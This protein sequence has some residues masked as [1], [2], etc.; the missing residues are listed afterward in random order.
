MFDAVRNN[1]K[2]VN[3]FLMLIILPFAFWGVES[4]VRNVGGANDLASVG[5]SK[6][7]P[8][9]FQEALQ[10]YGNRMRGNMG[11]QFKPEM[12]DSPQVRQAV[13]DGLI[14]RRL[15]ILQA[16]DA[17]LG[18]TNDQL[19]EVIQQIPYFQEDGKFSR[20]RYEA[21][22]AQQ[23]MNTAMFEDRL[24]QDL[25]LQQVEASLTL[26]GQVARATSDRWLALQKEER[27]VADF[28]LRPDAYL[29]QVKLEADAAQKYYDANKTRFETPEQVKVDYLV[30]SADA[31][32]DKLAPTEAE[33][34]AWYDS[35]A[36]RYRAAEERRA[37]HILILADKAAPAA[38]VKAA[39]AKAEDILK[40][41]KQSPA[42]FA[43]LAKQYSEDP[44]SKDNGGDLGFFGHGA[45]VKAFED[46]AFSL[47][48][49][50][51]SDVIRSDFGFHIIR[52]TGIKGAKG[53]PL[54][55]VKPEI[56]AELKQQG[57]AR[58]FAEISEA[59][60]NLV[61]DQPDS[62]APAA[63]KFQ[64]TV[65]SGGWLNKGAKGTGV[66]DNEK[67][68][69]ALFSD[70]AI[71][72][73]HNTHAIEIAAKTLMAAHV[74]EHKPAALKPFAE[75]KADIEK[76]LSLEQAAK[77][78]QKDGEA[79]LEQLNKGQKLDLAWA[80]PH[81]LTRATNAGLPPEAM[82]DIFKRAADKLPGY[83]GLA[84]PNGN[85]VL[86]KVTAGKPAVADEAKDKTLREQ[87]ARFTAESDWLSYLA[88][89]RSRYPVKI[90]TALLE[91]KDNR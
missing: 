15:L 62:L 42:N 66:L 1:K 9:D 47:K 25:T 58:K 80:T 87:Y 14:V 27:E 43:A 60:S 73:K 89:L 28:A 40:Q 57:G 24:R 39:Q 23:G 30:L 8:R 82:R 31:L 61:E 20:A 5:E 18:V 79:K 65:Q 86:F 7:S 70:D 59:F 22:L 55:E 29:G 76:R 41:V 74:A 32:A 12:L 46:T 75:V 78:A 26:S 68:I 16:H 77:L 90:N 45:M 71:K 37:S 49:G 69:A 35:H 53:K 51:I 17:R 72:G 64:L 10:E 52:V 56:V 83:V 4:Y 85:Y 88:A 2:L 21:V 36:D 38:T 84:A 6:I 13:L 19:P 63:E 81:A 48:E 54:E 3:I 44:G 11:A 91:A 34:K 50:Q 33:I 67:V